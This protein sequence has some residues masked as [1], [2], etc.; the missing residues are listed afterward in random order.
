LKDM[1]A[2]LSIGNIPFQKQ[3]TFCFDSESFRYLVALQE[4]IQFSILERQEYEKSWSTSA[5]EADRFIRYIREHVTVHDIPNQG[6]MIKRAQLNIVEMIRPI[7]N[8]LRNILKDIINCH[9]NSLKEPKKTRVKDV[10]SH[11]TKN[12]HHNEHDL[13][14][15]PLTID[16]LRNYEVLD[17]PLS[18]Q[19]DNMIAELSLI[20]HVSVQFAHFLIHVAHYRQDDPFLSGLSR[21]ITEENNGDK[22]QNQSSLSLRLAE[23]L[24]ELENDYKQRMIAA[25]SN[26]KDVTL[27]DI[28][29]WIK[30]IHEHPSIREQLSTAEQT[31]ETAIF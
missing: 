4:K 27:S 24:K 9:M 6:Q 7:L 22:S 16:F 30:Y 8:A 3:N 20:F 15:Q 29:E 25:K 17:G 11:P 14:N 26:V 12:D 23:G 13:P 19:Q 2:S 31:E 10:P 1:L 18:Q 28:N 21:L 5:T